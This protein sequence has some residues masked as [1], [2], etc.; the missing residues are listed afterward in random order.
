MKIALRTKTKHKRTTKQPSLGPLQAFNV[1]GIT[2]DA[3]GVARLNGKVTFIEGALPGE[4]V[5]ARISKPGKRYD[6]AQLV[7]IKQTSDKRIQPHCEHF[8]QC[9]G[10]SFQHLQQS[11]QLAYKQTWLEGQLRKVSN[12][13]T[14]SILSDQS[15]AYR[16][17][18]RVSVWAR[19]DKV[20]IGFRGKASKNIVDISQCV[21][22]TP[23]LQK[24]YGLLKQ[25]LL[26]DSLVAK[27]GHL[28]LLEDDDGAAITL[29]LIKPISAETKALWQQWARENNLVIYWQE[30]QADKAT[31]A[32]HPRRYTVDKLVLH[33]HPQD[34]IQV[35]AGLNKLMI[36]QAIE[37]LKPNKDD[38]ILDLFC[39]VGNFSLPLA[40]RAKEVIGI[41]VQSTMVAAGKENAELNKLHNLRF[42]A[43]DLTQP[44]NKEL[45]KLGVTKVLL[46]PPRAG[47]FEFLP[48][49]L[50]LKPLHIVYVSCDPA[51]LARDAEYLV[52]NRYLVKRISMMDMFPQ[53]SHLES[54]LLFERI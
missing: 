16:R 6:E 8:N 19:D 33:Y 22:L 44:I 42:L 36:A 30:P 24:V 39:G 51:T 12:A 50:K 29:R 5:E 40:Q 18:A 21:V 14:I 13:Q 45:L 17:R 1:E 38:V 10:C 11:D 35:N 7:A 53:T 26:T 9:G 41:E 28:E 2:H 31:M 27:I 52:A 32:Q 37:W 34:F 47:A 23:R 25:A 15:F 48:T 20:L 4:L 49:L 3:K 43:A 54:M 46:D